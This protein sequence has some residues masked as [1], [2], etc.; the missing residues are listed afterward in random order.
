MFDHL[1]EGHVLV[2]EGLKA[3]APD[4]GQEFRHRRVALQVGAQHHGVGQQSHQ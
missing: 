4:P 2:F 1:L 3:H